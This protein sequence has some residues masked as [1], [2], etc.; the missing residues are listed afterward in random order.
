MTSIFGNSIFRVSSK[1][2]KEKMKDI[3]KRSDSK[4]LFVQH[5]TFQRIETEIQDNEKGA[6]FVLV[7]CFTILRGFETSKQRP[8]RFICDKISFFPYHIFTRYFYLQ[9]T[10]EYKMFPSLN[11]FHP[12]LLICQLDRFTAFKGHIL[13]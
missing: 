5:Q 10:H 2:N 11:I 8:D 12:N 13:I 9:L 1:Q 7:R 4:V 6:Y 3:K